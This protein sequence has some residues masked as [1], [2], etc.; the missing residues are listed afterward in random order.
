[1]SRLDGKTALITGGSSGIGEATV[2]RFVEERAKV[3]LFA[4]NEERANK[5]IRDLEGDVLFYKGDV[6]LEDDVKSAVDTVIKEWG[7]LDII[8]NNAGI[9]GPGGPVDTLPV[10]GFDEATDVLIKGV[11]LG[12]KHAARVM[13]PQCQ[14][15]IINCASIAGL[16]FGPDRLIYSS[17][18]AA[19]NHLTRMAAGELGEYGIRVNS[20]CPGAILTKMWFGGNE[21]SEKEREKLVDYFKGLMPFGVGFPVDIAN[22]VL[23][24]AS[25]ESRYVTGHY[26]VV[27]GGAS[28]GIPNFAIDI[29]EKELEEI[30]G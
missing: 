15:S 8:F 30:L 26:L 14:G 10:E 27:D 24:L 9:L 11:F 20:V 23:W 17:C 16:I 7:K 29:M 28:I 18:K 6:A 22:A 4:R 2:R 25:D 12:V 5:I 3:L 13:K 21:P 1:M 19:V